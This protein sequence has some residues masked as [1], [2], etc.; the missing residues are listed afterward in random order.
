MTVMYSCRG[1]GGSAVRGGGVTRSDSISIYCRGD[2]IPRPQL[3]RAL[4]RRRLVILEDLDSVSGAHMND[5]TGAGAEHRD[6][7]GQGWGSNG[8]WN[9]GTANAWPDWVE[10]Q[11]SSV[12]TIDEI[13]VFTV[14]NNYQAPIEP[15]PTMTFSLYGVR[16]FTVQYW[17]GTAWQTVPGG[18]VT[19][20]TLVWRKFVFAPVNQL[21]VQRCNGGFAAQCAGRFSATVTLRSTTW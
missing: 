20:N 7:K 13:D 8:G 6:R 2:A 21:F 12:Q 10:V 3:R 17:T 19:G 11:F 9:D 4:V 1:F 16:D 14:Q 18:T 5:G 15:T